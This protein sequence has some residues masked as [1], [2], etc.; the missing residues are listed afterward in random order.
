M[1]NHKD[2]ISKSNSA[3]NSNF[4]SDVTDNELSTL[5]SKYYDIK[6][7]NSLVGNRSTFQLRIIS[8][9]LH[10]LLIILITFD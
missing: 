9:E 4:E 1:A 6:Q 7:L 3:N 10:H 2:F 5:D 8:C